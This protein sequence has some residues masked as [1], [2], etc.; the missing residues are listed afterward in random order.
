[1]YAKLTNGALKTAPKKVTYNG[2]TVINPSEDKLLGLGYLPVTYTDMPADA[3]DGQHYE[4]HWE[5][6]GES[7][8]QA[9]ELADNPDYDT[10]PELSAEEALDII[11]GGSYDK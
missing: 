9:W 4:P 5:Q 2:C 11:T 6:A 1:M 8:I 3:P 10:E 7:I